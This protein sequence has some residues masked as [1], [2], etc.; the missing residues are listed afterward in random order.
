LNGVQG[1]GRRAQGIFIGREF[2]G[3]GEAQF[4]GQ[5]LQGFA[6]LV[7]GQLGKVR[8]D[9]RGDGNTRLHRDGLIAGGLIK[10][11][12]QWINEVEAGFG[13]KLPVTEL[14]KPTLTLDRAGAASLNR[15]I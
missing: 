1:L 9:K 7:R 13:E 8:L 12:I 14:C 15:F 5:F 4:T 6:G 2:D 3:V 10:R 11:E